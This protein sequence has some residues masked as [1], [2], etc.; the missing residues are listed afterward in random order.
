MKKEVEKILQDLKNAKNYRILDNGLAESS[1][2]DELKDSIDSKHKA[3]NI[4]NF[5]S[6]DYLNLS[7]N[8]ALKAEFL[9]NLESILQ[10]NDFLFTSS[11]SR[12]L[13]VNH[14]IYGRLEGF[15]AS[16]FEGKDALMF[17]SGYHL[18]ISVLQALALI[19][20]TLFLCDRLAHASI[21]DGLRL[22]GAHF[23]RYRH[24]DMQDLE[25]LLQEYSH[26]YSNVIIISEAL[27]SMDGDFCD[28][29]ALVALK[30]KYKNVLLYID[31]AHSVGAVGALG[32]CKESGLDSK[33]DFIIF[34]FGKA[35]SS[36]GACVLCAGEYKD[37]LVNKAR[38]LI[39][40]TAIAPINAAFTFFIFTKIFEFE[41]LRKNLSEISAFFRESFLES[42]ESLRLDSIESH[43]LRLLGSAHIISLVVGDNDRVL[44]LSEFLR[45]RGIFVPAIRAPSVPPNTARLRFSL[46]SGITRDDIS[47]VMESIL[48]FYSLESSKFLRY[49]P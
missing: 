22:G 36:L 46:H 47:K 29:Y 31:E 8:S 38:G 26:K 10:N 33:I 35:I 34:T 25:I 18:N 14:S 27:F 39:Y 12:I 1:A 20:H 23:R 13:N 40:S 11:T 32:L 42:M 43:K 30:Q 28:I 4:I 5:S 15:L 44:N 41:S 17:N 3:Q 9:Q 19:P 2:F 24:N 6:N 49:S 45:K 7:A 21:I 37:F 16:F 48:E